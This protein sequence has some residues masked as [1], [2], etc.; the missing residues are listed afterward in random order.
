M[1][2]SLLSILYEVRKRIENVEDERFKHALMYQYLIG[3]N[4]SEVAGNNAPSTNDMY[5]IEYDLDGRIV[6][7]VMF[8]VKPIRRP[9]FYRTCV[10]PLD[11]IYDPWVEQVRDWFLKADTRPFQLG[12]RPDIKAKSNEKYL[13]EKASEVFSG[14][15]W[16][17]D[18]Y[19]TSE[20]SRE[21]GDV[22][23]TSGQLRDLRHD[24]LHTMYGFSAVDL[25]CFG[26]WNDP[27]SNLAEKDDVEFILSSS[28]PRESVHTYGEIGETYINKLLIRFTDLEK[29][30]PDFTFKDYIDQKSRFRIS[31]RIIQLIKHINT[32]A[33][34]KL[35]TR[36]FQESM[37][38]VLDMLNE[39]KDEDSLKSNITEAMTLFEISYNSLK[40]EI[41]NPKGKRSITL[42]KDY[43]DE[44]RITYDRSMFETWE[45]MRLL[46]NYYDHVRETAK[47]KKVLAYY[48]EPFR[49]PIDASQLWEKILIKFEKSLVELIRL[50]NDSCQPISEDNVLPLTVLVDP[51]LE[52]TNLL[53]QLTTRLDKIDDELT[54]IKGKIDGSN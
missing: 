28:P 22:D 10:L 7:A 23:F 24:I 21:K 33:E 31:S 25:A 11:P 19:T 3:G 37:E 8:I 51:S 20:Y 2:E 52:V 44:H 54:G 45:H 30:S 35:D 48:N 41:N 49:M 16:Y 6:P 36:L 17:K 53:S 40:K 9:N 15:E 12:R 1:S 42:L 34:L 4:V 39:C 43:F 47:L 50:L 29:I 32:I 5:P 13:I 38:M 14:L 27:V 18:A 46:R 26:S